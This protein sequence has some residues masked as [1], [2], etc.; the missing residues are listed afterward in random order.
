MTSPSTPRAVSPTPSQLPPVPS[1]PGGYSIASTANQLSTFSLPLPPPPRPSHTVLTAGDIERSQEAYAGLVSSAKEYRLALAALG[2]AASAFGSALESCA[3]LK[4]ARAEPIGASSIRLGSGSGGGGGGGG[5][6][7]MTASFTNKAAAKPCTADTLMSAS[8][9]QHLVANH[10]QILSETVY[11]SFEVPLLDDLDR[12]RA[13]MDDEKD[14][15]E[16]RV[17][18]QSREI[19]RLEKEGLKLHRQRHRDVG[20]FRA[21]LV[22]LTHRLDGLTGL[23]ADYSRTLLHESQETSARIVD[24]SCS[25]VR[26]EID[27]FES[28]ARKGWSGG[29]LDDILDKGHDLFATDDLAVMDDDLDHPTTTLGGGGGPSSSSSSKLFSILPPRSILADSTASSDRPRSNAAV[30]A[31]SGGSNTGHHTRGDS[32]D[33]DH[34]RYQPL[35][36]VAESHAAVGDADSVMSA[37]FIKPRN[38]RPFSP[39]PIRRKPMGVTIDSLAALTSSTYHNPLP[40]GDVDDDDENKE[41]SAK[42]GKAAGEKTSAETIPT[43]PQ[44]QEEG[45]PSEQQ[46]QHEESNTN[47]SGDADAEG[48]ASPDSPRGR[49]SPEFITDES[50]PES[51]H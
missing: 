30:G 8:G 46:Q 47:D 44:K 41:N 17:R 32:F 2:T 36:A 24:A 1:S 29:G 21:H 10:Q 27:I 45:E 34:H 37:E 6:I 12:W 49:K 33:A 50:S 13:V 38:A 4:E 51:H 42:L 16:Q 23:H 9:V 48:S 43:P 25:L 14:Q 26:A 31:G 22:D 7:N 18:A 3:R 40:F 15:Y 20:R 28:L 35:T 19:K 5:S 11:R 39:Q